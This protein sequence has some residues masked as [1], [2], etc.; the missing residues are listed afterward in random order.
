LKAAGKTPLLIRRRYDTP[1]TSRSEVWIRN[2][3]ITTNW[4]DP[5]KAFLD[6]LESVEAMRVRKCPV[7]TNFFY[8]VRKDQKSCSKRCNA[9]RRVRSW[10]ANQARHEYKRKFKKAGFL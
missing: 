4:F 8:A 5:V 10:R 1:A 3:S 7:C 2:G 6:A 9:V